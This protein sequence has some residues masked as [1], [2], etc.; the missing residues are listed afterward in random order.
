MSCFWLYWTR[1]L[2]L[3]LG[4]TLVCV[5]GHARDRVLD[6]QPEGEEART[7]PLSTFHLA[8]RQLEVGTRTKVRVLH[9]G[10]SHTAA[11]ILTTTIR[12]DL[13]ARFGNGGRGFLLLG[14]PWKAYNP[15]DVIVMSQGRWIGKRAILTDPE[16]LA[17]KRFGLCGIASEP[18]GPEGTT[19]IAAPGEPPFSA[20][21]ASLTLLYLRQPLGG[22]FS[23]SLDG[24]PPTRIATDAPQYE[25]GIEQRT[26]GSGRH[27]ATIAADSNSPVRLFGA[28]VEAAQPGVVYDT[29]GVNGAFFESVLHWDSAMLASQVALRSPDLI[30][31]MYGTNDAGDKKLAPD[32][33]ARTMTV[34]LA[35]LRRGAP[36]A[37]CLIVGPPDGRS[38]VRR[39]VSAARLQWVVDV[40]RTVAREQGCAFI[41]ARALM[42]GAGSFGQWQRQGL[43]A[44]DGVHLTYRGYQMLGHLIAK[45]ML[46]PAFEPK[47]PS[48]TARRQRR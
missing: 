46:R 23:I 40:E 24:A 2:G 28:V 45:E 12:R 10:D 35:R 26:L 5:S 6:P 31:V 7:A 27:T 17:D 33:L 14:H 34:A 19:T 38:T 18:S 37:A 20:P 16:S 9:F 21:M 8:L 1:L 4:L 36:S 15:Q 48:G 44:P 25:L 39:P 41:D 43:A 3:S 30:V 22:E 42:G 13:Q 32:S 11:D 47:K 29:L